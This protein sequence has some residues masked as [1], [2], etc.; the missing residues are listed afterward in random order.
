VAVPAGPHTLHFHYRPP[1][2][3]A[4]VLISL[5]GVLAVLLLLAWPLLRLRRYRTAAT[6]R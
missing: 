3:T 4:S 2:W 1:T 6:P 5:A